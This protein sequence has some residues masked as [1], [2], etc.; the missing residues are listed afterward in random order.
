MVLILERDQRSQEPLT[1]NPGQWHPIFLPGYFLK[2]IIAI[3]ERDH[4]GYLINWH[5]IFLPGERSEITGTSYLESWTMAPDLLTWPFPFDP[6]QLTIP[7]T[8]GKK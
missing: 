3:L 8:T 6:E 7:K 1:R 4:N 5:P 2:S